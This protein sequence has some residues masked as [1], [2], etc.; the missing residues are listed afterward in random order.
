MHEPNAVRS[1]SPLLL[2]MSVLWFRPVH[3]NGAIAVL[4]HGRSGIAALQGGY[5]R[6]ARA[7]SR[8]GI[9]VALAEYYDRRDLRVFTSTDGAAI[10]AAYPARFHV[11]SR[12]VSA[13]VDALASHGRVTLVGF[14][15]GGFLAVDVAAHS[16]RV[17]SLVVEHAGISDAE[18]EPIRHLP[19]MLVIHGD[20]DRDVPL[21]ASLAFIALARRLGT[22][23]TLKRYPNE[24][25][26]FDLVRDD[27]DTRDA[28]RRVARF[29]VRGAAS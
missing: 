17:S 10:A 8:A 27:D 20:A 18:T 11:W 24:G 4:L 13:F 21:S 19:R 14:S 23:A 22:V 3:P 16:R 28:Q 12:S 2:A 9:R 26:V 6:E 25:H 1:M 5:D 15:Q 7:L 29:I